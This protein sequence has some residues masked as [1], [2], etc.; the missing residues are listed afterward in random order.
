MYLHKFLRRNSVSRDFYTPPGLFDL[1]D[2]DGNLFRDYGDQKWMTQIP[3]QICKTSL[4]E[5][6]QM[7]IQFEMNFETASYL[8]KEQ[9]LGKTMF[10]ET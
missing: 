5:Y 9:F 10:F 1:E 7:Y 3:Y 2:A 4:N 6:L 8:L